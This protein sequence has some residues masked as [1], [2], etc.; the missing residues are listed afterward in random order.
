MAKLSVNGKTREVDVAPDT[1]LL[2]VLRDH[3]ELTGTKY[4]CGMALCGACTVHVDGAAVRSCVTPVSAVAGKR[5]TTIEAVGATR[6]GRAVQTAWENLDVVQC[7]YCQSGQIMSAAA[8]LAKT[9]QPTRRGYRQRDGG[10]RLPLR[11]LCAHPRRHQDRGQT[12]GADDM[13]RLI[14]MSIENPQRREFLQVAALAGGGFAIGIVP[15]TGAAA[16]GGARHAE[17]VRAHERRQH[18]DGDRQAPRNGPGHLYR[19]ADAGGRRAGRRL[20]ADPRRGRARRR[21]A[22]TTTCCGA[23]R[24]APAA[25]PRWRIRSS[26]CARPARR[27]AP[28]W[29]RRRRKSGT[30]RRTPS[31]SAT[32]W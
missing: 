15:H 31:P 6:A 20:G 22:S 17:S 27:R 7:G 11:D 24:R 32:A 12:G 4:G 26:R 30:C 16:D 23:R 13:K 18:G 28:C 8:L 5:I 21:Q 25:A 1:P 9:P 29:W 19:L 14:D 10:Q 3:L 2:W